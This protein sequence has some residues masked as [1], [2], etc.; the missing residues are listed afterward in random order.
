MSTQGT[1][2]IEA[3]NLAAGVYELEVTGSAKANINVLNKL[4]VK[5]E[6]SSEVY[7]KGNPK[8]VKEK[9]SGAA[10]LEKVN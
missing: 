1:A 6:G 5:T 7:Y 4:S 8:D 9:K 10:K 3:F 2:T